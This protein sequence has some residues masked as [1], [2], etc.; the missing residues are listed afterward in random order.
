PHNLILAADG[1][2]KVLDF[3]L[4]CVVAG[5]AVAAHRGGLTRTGM[6]ARPAD[7]IAP[8]QAAA[9]PAP[10]AP[11]DLHGLGCTPSPLPAPP[12]PH[13][14]R[15]PAPRSRGGAGPASPPAKTARGPEPTP[16]LPAGLATVLA[17]MT[18]KRPEDRFRSAAEVVAPLEGCIRAADPKRR[19]RRR[20]AT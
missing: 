18:A 3:G 19:N 14:A 5:E 17:K 1:T 2:T 6:V 7:Y 4:A 20:V 12:P 10:D 16:G 9:P 13:P 8:Q 15:R 11:S